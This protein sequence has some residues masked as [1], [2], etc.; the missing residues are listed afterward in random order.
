MVENQY[1]DNWRK[2]FHYAT[3]SSSSPYKGP[4]C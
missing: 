3:I 2:S 1:K 4:K